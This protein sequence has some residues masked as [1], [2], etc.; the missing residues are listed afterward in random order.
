MLRNERVLWLSAISAI[1]FLLYGDAW[2]DKLHNPFWYAGISVWLFAIILFAAIGAVRHAEILAGKLGEPYGT[3]IL[4]IAVTTIEVTMIANIILSGDNNPGFARDTM[5]AVVM[6]VFNGLIGLALL[7]GALRFHEQQYNL[8]GANSYLVVIIPLA[9]F[10]LILPDFTISTP[11]QSFSNFQA[12]FLVLMSLGLYMAFLLIQTKRHQNYFSISGD[13]DTPSH[14]EARIDHAPVYRITNHVLLLV[15]Y[16]VSVILLAEQIAAPIDYSI[17]TM[18]APM[19]LGGFL[20]ATLILAPEAMSGIRAALQ[21]NLQRAVNIL[22]GSVL[23]T[24]SLTIPAVLVIS[25]ISNQHTILGL[26]NAEAVLLVVTLMVSMTTFSSA[27]TNILHGGVHFL[28]FLAYIML[29]FQ[30]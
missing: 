3:L 5:F 8:Q 21:N 9:G 12:A 23:A 4:T 14:G 1:L 2:M 10:G 20:V 7:L 30:P 6:I 11:D 19:A 16:L 27:R 26:P 25:Y 28:L 22:L 18:G 17:E 29:I 24:I 15:G 13:A